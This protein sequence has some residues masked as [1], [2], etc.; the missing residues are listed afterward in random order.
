MLAGQDTHA[1]QLAVQSLFRT[2]RAAATPAAAGASTGSPSSAADEGLPAVRA[3]LGAAFGRAPKQAPYVR[4]L[5]LLALEDGGAAGTDPRSAA[6]AARAS[7]SLQ[8]GA[9]QV[10]VAAVMHTAMQQP[11]QLCSTSWTSCTLG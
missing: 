1:A 10:G 7:G 5:Q 6:E 9:L 2:L 4:A 8:A 11:L 3:A